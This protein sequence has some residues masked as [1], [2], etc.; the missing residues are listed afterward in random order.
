MSDITNQFLDAIASAGPTPPE[1]IIDDGKIHRFSSN[2]KPR[3]ES[4]WYV[5]HSDG[6]AAGAFGCWREGFTQNWCSKSTT[7]MTQA[8]REA[9][10][11]RVQAMKAQR[12]SEQAQRNESA[13]VDATSQFKAATTCTSHPY[14]T[15]KGIQSHGIRQEGDNLLIP[16]RDAAGK[17][18][19]LQ[20]ITLDGDK[21]FLFG[22]R[23]KGCYHPIGKIKSGELIVKDGKL[24]VCEGYATGASIFEAT[25]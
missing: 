4:G 25:G 7:E 18:H 5:L 10:Q 16:M 3:D 19:S 6:V 11:N 2:G 1:D 24:I 21:R 17:L 12:D 14:L 20:T 9:H 8:E 15:T 23:I 22:G 13:A